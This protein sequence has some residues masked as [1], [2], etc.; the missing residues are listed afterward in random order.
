[1]MDG[2]KINT[3]SF[4]YNF[5]LNNIT[6]DKID[7]LFINIYIA[8]DIEAKIYLITPSNSNRQTMKRIY[9]MIENT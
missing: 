6:I 2:N 8:T 3:F 9:K 4:F 1:M 7:L 5:V